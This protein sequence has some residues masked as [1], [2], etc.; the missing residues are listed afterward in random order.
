MAFKYCQTG[1]IHVGQVSSFSEAFHNVSL[2][3][4]Q[5][6]PMSYYI[7]IK[8]AITQWKITEPESGDKMHI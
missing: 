6:F 1:T 3:L 7:E 4:S 5:N 8:R 2:N